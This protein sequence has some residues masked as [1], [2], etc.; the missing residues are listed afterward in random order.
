M[1]FNTKRGGSN[2]QHRFR[3]K[4]PWPEGDSNPRLIRL[5]NHFL[6]VEPQAF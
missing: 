2:L 5:Q 6:G 3:E 4:N 1:L